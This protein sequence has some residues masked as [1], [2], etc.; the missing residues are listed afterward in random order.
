MTAVP[1]E[2][3]DYLNEVIG[4]ENVVRIYGKHFIYRFY[5]TE[6]ALDEK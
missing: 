2:E 4:K 3:C 6:D 5:R 1:T